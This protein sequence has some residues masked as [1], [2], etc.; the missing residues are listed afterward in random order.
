MS[1]ARDAALK[2]LDSGLSDAVEKVLETY[3]ICLIDANGDAAKEAECRAIR[4]RSL[5]Y[6]KRAYSDMK[7]A[8]DQQWPA[9]T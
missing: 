4:D 5:G 1:E 8:V 2:G 3:E 9:A 6:A 7:T